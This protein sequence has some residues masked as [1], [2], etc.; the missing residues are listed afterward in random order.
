[1][2]ALLAGEDDNL[3]SHLRVLSELALSSPQVF[4]QKAEEMSAFLKTEILD[5]ESP[6]TEVSC[7]SQLAHS[8]VHCGP[9]LKR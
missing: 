3:L 2:I 4:E 6:I 1:M 7:R 9:P 5:R 8:C